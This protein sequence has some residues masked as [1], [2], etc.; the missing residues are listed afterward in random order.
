MMGGECGTYGGQQNYHKELVWKSK[1][2]L[3]RPKGKWQNDI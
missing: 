2:E 1:E 3:R